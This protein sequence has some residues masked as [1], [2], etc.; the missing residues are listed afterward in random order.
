LKDLK[1]GLKARHSTTLTEAEEAAVVA[2]WRHTVLPLD[3][4]LY[5]LLP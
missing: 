2:F 1:T 4:C 5:A 3:D